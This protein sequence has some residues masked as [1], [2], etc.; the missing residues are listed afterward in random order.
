MRPIP[1]VLARRYSASMILRNQLTVNHDCHSGPD[2]FMGV[3]APDRQRLV[4]DLH[5]Q[6]AP[7]QRRLRGHATG[8]A[9]REAMGCPGHYERIQHVVGGCRWRERCRLRAGPEWDSKCLR[10]QRMSLGVPLR[11][12]LAECHWPSRQRPETDFRMRLENA[13]L[14]LPGHRPVDLGDLAADVERLCGEALDGEFMSSRQG[15]AVG[16]L[17]EQA[18]IGSRKHARSPRPKHL[19][20]GNVTQA[21]SPSLRPMGMSTPMAAASAWAMSRAENEG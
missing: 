15:L 17:K 11:P 20:R 21:A 7:I 18:R 9:R 8:F 4:D 1:H 14:A 6:T 10:E 13:I 16:W 2:R 12:G 3:D 5:A 19:P